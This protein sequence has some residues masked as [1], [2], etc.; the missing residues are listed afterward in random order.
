MEFLLPFISFMLNIF[1]SLYPCVRCLRVCQISSSLQQACVNF[2][3][4]SYI[5]QYDPQV[6]NASC[7]CLHG[8]VS[9]VGIL[10]PIPFFCSRLSF[11]PIKKEQLAQNDQ[12]AHLVE[13]WIAER[14]LAGSN[15]GQ[16][17][18][19]QSGSAFAF[20]SANG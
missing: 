9:C 4:V 13:H 19:Q 10:S 20:T 5:S 7:S 6:R 18:T 2:P 3:L 17:N 11:C 1:T 16:T 8:K 14:E 15:R 12:L